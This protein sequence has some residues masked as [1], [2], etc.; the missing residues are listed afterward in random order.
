MI[1]L[2]DC[3]HCE[4]KQNID[5]KSVDRSKTIIEQQF[6]GTI[7]SCTICSRCQAKEATTNMISFLPLTL[8]RQERFFTIL[9]IPL[10]GSHQQH[11][12][13]AFSTDRL[14]NV[15]N[16]FAKQSLFE[17]HHRLSVSTF[18]SSNTYLSSNT[19]LN[20][21]FDHRLIV[22]EEKRGPL[23]IPFS[24]SEQ[25]NSLPLTLM[26]CLEEFLA[27]ELL[28]GSWFCKNKCKKE[29][30]SAARKINLCTLPPVLIFQLKRFSEKNGQKHKIDKKVMFPL[31]G[32]DLSGLLVGKYSTSSAPVYD[33]VAVSNHIGTIFGGHCTTYARQVIDGKW[34]HFDDTD[35]NEIQSTKVISKDAYLLFYIRRDV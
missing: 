35:V 1:F 15:L 4:L 17:F 33:L 30:E 2:L 18:S 3:L 9:Y 14:E 34:Y 28:D 12:I 20:E 10:S 8:E 27:L 26:N 23:F 7:E 29:I 25:S 6:F 11:C 32:L 19:P 13:S 16:N 24:I 21:I 22:R 31:N 5:S